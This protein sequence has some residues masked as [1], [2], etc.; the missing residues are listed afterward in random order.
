MTRALTTLCKLRA[1]IRDTEISAGGFIA[2][3]MR[4][5]AALDQIANVADTP[6]GC[7]DNEVI[8]LLK[9]IARK[10][11]DSDEIETDDLAVENRK[12]LKLARHADR[13]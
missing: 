8:E 1:E 9:A 5:Y 12:L 11:I 4:Y 3:A 6:P 2:L 13:I 7:T 10:A